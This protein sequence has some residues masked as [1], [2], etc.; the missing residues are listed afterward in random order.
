MQI[1]EKMGGEA[2]VVVYIY[3]P[4]TWEDETWRFWVQ[5]G[6]TNKQL[7][8]NLKGKGQWWFYPNDILYV[9]DEKGGEMAG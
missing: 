4:S 8:D 2:G 3:N 1:I 5:P 9:D 6:V 7:T